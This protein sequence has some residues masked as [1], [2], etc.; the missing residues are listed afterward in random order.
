MAPHHKQA[1]CPGP[2]LQQ[3]RG[4]NMCCGLGGA[5]QKTR[6]AGWRG[7]GAHSIRP[8]VK[9]VSEWRVSSPPVKCG[10]FSRQGRRCGSRPSLPYFYI[11]VPETR[12][13]WLPGI[14]CHGACLRQCTAAIRTCAETSLAMC[15]GEGQYRTINSN[16]E[17][18]IRSLA[19]RRHSRALAA[20][21]RLP[22]QQ[23]PPL[24]PSAACP[25]ACPL[26]PALMPALAFL[27]ALTFMI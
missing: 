10:F 2:T 18:I 5:E 17:F 3:P 16:M 21:A 24:P 12:H 27:T 14:S 11:P 6:L 13:G 25:P 7:N 4:E 9:P 20:E 26:L 1:S 8:F 15:S 23:L 22:R 19:R